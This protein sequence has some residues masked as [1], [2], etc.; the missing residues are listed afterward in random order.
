MESEG[1]RGSGKQ[2]IHIRED[3]DRKT[4]DPVWDG[5]ANLWSRDDCSVLNHELFRS[6][7]RGLTKDLKA[8][9]L[10]STGEGRFFYRYID[11]I[12]SWLLAPHQPRRH[13]LARERVCAPVPYIPFHES[14]C[15]LYLSPSLIIVINSTCLPTRSHLV[16]LQRQLCVSQTSKWSRNQDNFTQTLTFSF[17]VPNSLRSSLFFSLPGASAVGS[18]VWKM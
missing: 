15:L 14:K 12:H 10:V 6:L 7:K 13:I 11:A 16:H 18:E 8:R 3:K 4:T 9:G 17:S 2:Y 1:S 5:V